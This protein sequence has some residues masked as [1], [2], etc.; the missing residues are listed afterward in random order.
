MEIAE[1]E[2]ASKSSFENSSDAGEKKAARKNQL[3]LDDKVLAGGSYLT[4]PAQPETVLEVDE[5]AE[6]EKLEEDVKIIVEET[7]DILSE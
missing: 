3:S 1:L 5:T 7:D 6:E 4:S 2:K